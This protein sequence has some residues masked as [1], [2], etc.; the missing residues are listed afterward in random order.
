MTCGALWQQW[1][2][3]SWTLISG[4]AE[5]CCDN[6]P[7]FL[8]KIEPLPL[9]LVQTSALPDPMDPSWV[10]DAEL[11]P[12]G[13]SPGQWTQVGAWK[14]RQFAQE[15]QL[16]HPA[17]PHLTLD[18][19]RAEA[20]E[21]YTALGHVLDMPAPLPFRLSRWER[22]KQWLSR[23]VWNRKHHAELDAARKYLV[24]EWTR[25]GPWGGGR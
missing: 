1:A 15:V 14:H 23:K 18:L 24:D 4:N 8:A 25:R 16:R 11:E 12:R 5:Q 2:D 19:F 17:L 3:L 21:L 20:E 6:A 7:D 10:K 22:V 9:R 13:K